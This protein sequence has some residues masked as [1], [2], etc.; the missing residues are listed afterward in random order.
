MTQ[1]ELAPTDASRTVPKIVLRAGGACPPEWELAPTDGSRPRIT[2][3]GIF[4]H[5]PLI[6]RQLERCFPKSD[7]SL[8]NRVQRYALFP[9]GKRIRPLLCIAAYRACGGDSNRAILPFACGIELIHSFSLIQDDLPAMDNDLKRR[10]KPTLHVAFGEAVALL[11]SDALFSRAF[12]LFT[13]SSARCR[14]KIPAIREIA[15]AIGRQGVVEGQLEDIVR[16][17]HDPEETGNA[18]CKMQNA[19]CNNSRFG[20]P[21]LFSTDSARVLRRIHLLKTARLIAVSMKVGALIA[22]APERVAAGLEQA[23]THLGMLFQITDDLLDEGRPGENLTY[24]KLYGRAGARRHARAHLARYRA[25]LASL[26]P[27][28]AASGFRELLSVGD[29]VL[30]R[31]K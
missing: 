8:L 21:F 28:L 15:Q 17:G 19:K 20:I 3:Q 26:R 23:G 9:G 13:R 16:R 12:E 14:Q 5:R 7:R 6:E 22:E 2:D 18:K 11:A 30:D 31:Q 4:R 29:L 25:V 1:W 27:N 10:G 24:P